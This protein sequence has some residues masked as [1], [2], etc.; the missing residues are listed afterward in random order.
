MSPPGADEKQK[1]RAMW[2]EAYS[3]CAKVVRVGQKTRRTKGRRMSELHRSP[4]RMSI[5]KRILPGESET[6]VMDDD[7][8]DEENDEIVMR[9]P[10]HFGELSIFFNEVPQDLLV[11]ADEFSTAVFLPSEAVLRVANMNPVLRHCFFVFRTV[12]QTHFSET[13]EPEEDTA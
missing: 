6:D 7:D 3:A 8:L 1:L 12:V 9:A 11:T 2:D 5:L 13:D 4:T 10:V